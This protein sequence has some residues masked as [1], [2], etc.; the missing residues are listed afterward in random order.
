MITI[1]IKCIFSFRANQFNID[2]KTICSI[3]QLL[4]FII[5]FNIE[6]ST[7]FTYILAALN[8]Y[9]V[10]LLKIDDFENENIF[11]LIVKLQQDILTTA[12]NIIQHNIDNTINNYQIFYFN[13]MKPIVAI[14]YAGMK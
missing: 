12:H 13:I 3:H 8:L 10:V 4:E 14:C 1:I 6:H 9:A 2:L 5:N 11:S 7:D